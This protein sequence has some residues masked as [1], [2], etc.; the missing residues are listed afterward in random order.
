M[1][2][3]NLCT[4]SGNECLLR[5]D[6]VGSEFVANLLVRLMAGDDVSQVMRG[7]PRLVPGKQCVEC[8]QRVMQ[9]L[10]PLKTVEQWGEQVREGKRS[11]RR[12]RRRNQHDAPSE[13]TKPFF[14]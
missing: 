10:A 8:A 3:E 13:P 5:A 7:R 11:N 2:A 4:D 1:A 6:H 12:Q 9:D 14:R